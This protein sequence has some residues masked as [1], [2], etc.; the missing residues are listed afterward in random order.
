MVVVMI[1]TESRTYE[2]VVSNMQEIRARQGRIVAIAN[3]NAHEVFTHA[4]DV[5]VVP[6]CDEMLSPL[7]NVIPLQYFA[8]FVARARGCDID[9]PRN[10]AK[11]VT[12]E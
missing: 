2:K 9:K 5:I 4:E 3:E 12:V 10:L 6:R 1:A 11:S 8:Y 7:V